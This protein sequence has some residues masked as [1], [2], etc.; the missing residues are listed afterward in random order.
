MPIGYFLLYFTKSCDFVYS[1]QEVAVMGKKLGVTKKNK[2]SE[3]SSLCISKKSLFKRFLC[4]LK[5]EAT[6]KIVICPELNLEDAQYDH[7]KSKSK[8]YLSKW[9]LVKEKFFKAWNV[10]PKMWNF[11]IENI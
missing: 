2:N 9:M 4:I 5:K 6:L 1:I 7:V 3:A 10:K 8:D 11:Y